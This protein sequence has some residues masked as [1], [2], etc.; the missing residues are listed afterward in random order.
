MAEPAQLDRL[1][2]LRTGGEVNAAIDSQFA[3]F[4]D[5]R[6]V[7][8]ARDL[9][10]ISSAGGKEAIRAA[11]AVKEGE[12]RFNVRK[13]TDF[14]ERFGAGLKGVT[15][16]SSPSEVASYKKAE[17]SIRENKTIALFLELKSLSNAERIKA[18]TDPGMTA[19]IGAGLNTYSAVRNEALNIIIRSDAIKS[20]F[21][22][23][24]TN[25]LSE[26]QKKE[27]VE[28]TLFPSDDARFASRFGTRLQEVY[29]KAVNLEPVLTD[30]KK[31]ELEQQKKVDEAGLDQNAKKIAGLLVSRG[32]THPSGA[33]ITDS[34]VK[35]WL[36]TVAFTPESAGDAVASQV[37]GV[38]LETMSNL[39][40]LAVDIPN[41][42]AKL[43][44]TINAKRGA[45]SLAAYIADPA[46]ANESDVLMLNTLNSEYTALNAQYG[47]G[48]PK[49]ADLIAFNSSSI[50]GLFI[51]G[52]LAGVCSEAK[53]KALN[54]DSITAQLA[55]RP[56]TQLEIEKS[57]DVRNLQEEDLLGEMDGILGQ[58]IADVLEERYDAMEERMGRL[59]EQQQKVKDENLKQK[60]L[61][62]KKAMSRNWIMY[63][64][65]TRSKSINK[66]QIKKDV[67]H[68]AYHFD[69]DVALKQL[70]ARDLFNV[71]HYEDLNLIDGK[72]RSG[73]VILDSD[74]LAVVGKVFEEAGGEYRDK[75]FADM[76]AARGVFDRTL[77]FG[78]GMEALPSWAKLGFK[79]D[80][81]KYMMQRYEPEITKALDNNHDA[82]QA[83]K[84]LEAQG[85]KMDT[86]MKWLWYI[87]AVLFGG[88]AGGV[89]G[90]IAPG[91]TALEGAGVGAAA[92]VIAT[93][94]MLNKEQT[95]VNG[96]TI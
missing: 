4:R 30:E 23:L 8:L 80:E 12:T 60:I 74:Q 37:L 96:N 65:T 41:S 20:L 54:I 42:Q 87:L 90:A 93:K 70:I 64:A 27:F 84:T 17:Q 21:P 3:S 9:R 46:H 51:D 49:N 77:N 55:A 6:S 92:E 79:R 25:G 43:E 29:K 76:F 89:G 33:A 72:N 36:N 53:K 66:D 35:T 38:S 59:T 2:L 28:S 71:T 63:N 45:V 57:R 95:D 13:A 73:T 5:H 40:R 61:E 48:G 67:T 19:E 39:R 26:S 78:F 47:T 68:L 86:N 14:K 22:E 81:W 34:D 10:K 94:V 1:T 31:S 69:K 44:S 24:D 18:L 15:P 88:A 91:I 11:L 75:L 50:K 32:L 56:A 82:H 85:V 58:S 52:S 7:E 16:P 62:L 83:M